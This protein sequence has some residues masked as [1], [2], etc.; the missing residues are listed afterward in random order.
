MDYN[1]EDYQIH[2]VGAGVSGLI[3]AQV[4]ESYGYNPTIYEAGTRAGGRLKTDII[5]GYQ[6]DH[7][8]QVMLTAYPMTQ[9]YLDYEQLELQTFLPGASI[10][11]KNKKTTIGDPT[12]EASLLL[13]TLMANLGRLS[14]KIK[15][16]QLNRTLKHKSLD[17]IFNQEEKST[18]DYLKDY[19]FSDELIRL[20]FRPFFSGIFLEPELQTSSRMFE[21]VFK[22]FGSG[23]AALPKA[24]I[25]AIVSQLVDKLDRT[26]LKFNTPVKQVENGRLI[27]SNGEVHENHYAI[28]ATE[29]N[30][31]V[32][33]LNYLQSK[34]HDCDCLYFE[35]DQ[36]Q[37]EKA[38]IGLVS[39][40]EA[41]INNI[42]YH[43]SL[44]TVNTAPK[45]LLSVTVV[46]PHNFSPDELRIKV[47]KD[48]ERFCGIQQCKFIKH[49]PIKKSLPQ[50]DDLKHAMLPSQTKLTDK[51]YL[52]GDQLLN[53]SLNAAMISGETAAMGIIEKQ[54][55]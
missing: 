41:L 50:L 44:G 5:N 9:K 8:F 30:Q 35:C 45:E 52:A 11:F 43:T 14:D 37:I 21:F 20:F 24:G 38:L 12:R 10:F 54:T 26:T 2:I 1:K 53:G 7:G 23:L 13:P 25:E 34:W 28:I 51:I 6:L 33:N 22:M 47:E 49:Y 32:R 16:F 36:R 18:M 3:A 39:D 40:P 31:L 4:L 55:R 48:L 19:G 27:L 15:I 42:F 17:Q 29:A 46:K